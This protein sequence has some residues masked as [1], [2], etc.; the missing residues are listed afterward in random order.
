MEG[1]LYFFNW[2]QFGNMSD[3][4]PAHSAGIECLLSVEQLTLITGCDDGKIRFVRP[5]ARSSSTTTSR[6]RAV[7]LYPHR[8]VSVLGRTSAMPIQTLSASC[9]TNYILGTST[10]QES[11]QL[12]DGRQL[13]EILKKKKKKVGKA[14]E[15]SFFADLESNEQPQDEQHETDDDDDDDDDT[16]EDAKAP[17]RKKK[18]NGNS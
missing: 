18:K 1:V 16:D 10:S 12:I 17:P 5:F 13:K 8:V 15:N 6:S 3:R 9:D 14:S 11:L 4:Y 2:K 7:S